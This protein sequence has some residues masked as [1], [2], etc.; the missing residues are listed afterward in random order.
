[1]YTP[2]LNTSTRTYQ[3]VDFVADAFDSERQKPRKDSRDFPDDFCD[4]F[5][6]QMKRNHSEHPEGIF[7]DVKTILCGCFFFNTLN[8]LFVNPKLTF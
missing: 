4:C 3:V 2:V 5:V 6:V 1:M 7:L 8:R